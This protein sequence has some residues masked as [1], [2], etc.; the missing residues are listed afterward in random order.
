MLR[1]RS[2]SLRED[3]LE[4]RA[5]SAA[6]GLHRSVNVQSGDDPVLPAL[7]LSTRRFAK[8]ATVHVE[9]YRSVISGATDDLP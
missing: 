9:S 5:P 3:V 1:D 2:A 4:R 6:C 7:S 8:E